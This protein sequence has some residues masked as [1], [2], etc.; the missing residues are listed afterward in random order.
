MKAV[1][2]TVLIVATFGFIWRSGVLSFERRDIP[3]DFNKSLLGRPLE[4]DVRS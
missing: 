1:L 2:W 4:G 3:D